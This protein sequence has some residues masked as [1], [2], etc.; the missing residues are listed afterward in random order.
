MATT[1]TYT[2]TQYNSTYG[3]GTCYMILTYD[4]N[5]SSCKFYLGARKTSN[6]YT[7]YYYDGYVD[8]SLN[9]GAWTTWV[10]LNSSSNSHTMY[11]NA[12]NNVN[13]YAATVGTSVGGITDYTK[14]GVVNKTLTS[15][16]TV[17]FRVRGRRST[18]FF[19]WYVRGQAWYIPNNTTVFTINYGG[20]R[21]WDG[22]WKLALPYVYNSGWKLALPYVYNSGWKIST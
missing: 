1:L 7:E 18:D 10:T 14:S 2:M 4:G 16:G 15:I 6:S 3:A 19:L 21:V 5:A 22:S 9:G 11:F 8:Y 17:S 12:T 13:Y 20:V